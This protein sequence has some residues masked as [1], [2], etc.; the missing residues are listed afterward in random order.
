MASQPEFD[1]SQSTGGDGLDRWH[2]QRE[3]ASHR[4]ARRLG[5]PL[6][7]QVEVW[8]KD[9]VRLRGKLRLKESMLFLEALDEHDLELAID[10]VT[11]HF[12]EMESCLRLDNGPAAK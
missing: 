9:G 4:L 6:E 5:L 10:K 1:F 2:Q 3:R 8:L 11:F 7:R 12:A